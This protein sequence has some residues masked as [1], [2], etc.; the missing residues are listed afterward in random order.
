MLTRRPSVRCF[1]PGLVLPL[2]NVT[3]VGE[4]LTRFRWNEAIFPAGKP[5]WTVD[6]PEPDFVAKFKADEAAAQNMGLEAGAESLSIADILNGDMDVMD[7]FG[8][9]GRALAAGPSGVRTSVRC[10]LESTC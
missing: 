10:D 6:V 1:A 5:Q 7:Q 3:I 4:L 8:L 9:L 2:L